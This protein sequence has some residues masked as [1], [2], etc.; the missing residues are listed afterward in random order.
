MANWLTI[1]VHHGEIIPADGWRRAYGESLIEAAVT[2]GAQ[3]WKWHAPRWTLTSEKSN[4]FN[5]Q[6]RADPGLPRECGGGRPAAEALVPA[7][8]IRSS[9]QLRARS[10]DR[11]LPRSPL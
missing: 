2:N 8:V 6:P 5:T 7:Y 1:E 4:G 11:A 9:R 10:D 3:G